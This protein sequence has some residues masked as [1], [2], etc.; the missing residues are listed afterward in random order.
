MLQRG[1]MEA[2]IHAGK[3]A[4]HLALVADVADEEF[5]ARHLRE[6]LLHVEQAA[7]IVVY[8]ANSFDA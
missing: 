7:L 4:H 6:V 3:D 8:D 1:G 5:D 2:E